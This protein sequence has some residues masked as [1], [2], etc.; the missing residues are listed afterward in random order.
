MLATMRRAV[1]EGLSGVTLEVRASNVA[2][3]ELYRR[4]GFAPG[5][6][7]RNYYADL[8]EDALIMWAHDLDSDRYQVRLDDIEA[9]LPSPLPAGATQ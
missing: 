8:R 5:G 6:I 7:R 1:A 3:Q 2:A 9:A 4:F